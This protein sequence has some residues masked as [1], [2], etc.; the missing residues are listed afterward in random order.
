MGA[1]SFCTL[2]IVAALSGSVVAG[3]ATSETQKPA[4][5][6][7]AGGIV[8]KDPVLVTP[9]TNAGSLSAKVYNKSGRRDEIT[10]VSAKR[11]STKLFV[12]QASDWGWSSLP[13]TKPRT[14]GI[15]IHGDPYVVRGVKPGETVQLTMSFKHANPLTFDAEVVADGPR[16]SKIAAYPLP[17]ITN[18]RFVVVSGQKCAYVGYTISGNGAQQSAPLDAVTVTGPDG[19]KIPWRHQTATGG[20]AEIGAPAGS[21]D[22]EPQTDDAGCDGKSQGGDADYVSAADVKVGE[23]VD[24]AIEFPAGIVHTPFKIVAR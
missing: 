24:V 4:D 16:Y 5:T 2:A 21:A 20:S 11:G 13:L 15:P 10:N 23:T 19:R 22:F 18:G 3:C 12:F 17:S 8:I 6:F 14:L 7:K 1:H 9:E